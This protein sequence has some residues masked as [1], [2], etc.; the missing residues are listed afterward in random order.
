MLENCA[1]SV[2][3]ES[4]SGRVVLCSSPNAL[5]EGLSRG[6]MTFR[7]DLENAKTNL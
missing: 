2:G 6:N 7:F 3:H 5:L 1:V 4:Y